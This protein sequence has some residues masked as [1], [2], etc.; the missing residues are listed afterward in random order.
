MNV[1]PNLDAEYARWRDEGVAA[2]RP[3]G[4]FVRIDRGSALFVSDAPRHGFAAS[5]SLAALFMLRQE[6]QLLFLSPRLTD[7]PEALRA[8]Y[9]RL[10]KADPVPRDRMLRQALAECLRLHRAEEAQFLER[11]FEGGI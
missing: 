9:L 8:L 3:C 7:V 5:P 1:Y 4:A 6:K 2:L 10:L 11:I